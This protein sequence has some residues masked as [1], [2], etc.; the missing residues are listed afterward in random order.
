M[1]LIEH[2]RHRRDRLNRIKE[3]FLQQPPTERSHFLELV[4]AKITVAFQR[5]SIKRCGIDHNVATDV[6][7]AFARQHQLS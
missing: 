5:D 1:A 4:V 2:D 3:Q 6:L 7:E